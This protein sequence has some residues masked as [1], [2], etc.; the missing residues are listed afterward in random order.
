MN[1]HWFLPRI[2]GQTR[3]DFRFAGL[4]AIL[5]NKQRWQAWRMMDL[6]FIFFI[7]HIDW[8]LEMEVEVL[9]IRV[10]LVPSKSHGREYLVEITNQTPW[11]IVVEDR[12]SPNLRHFQVPS[13]SLKTVPFIRKHDQRGNRIRCLHLP[14]DT[15]VLCEGKPGRNWCIYVAKHGDKVVCHH[16]C[17]DGS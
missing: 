13:R 15:N 8:R 11:V 14:V 6:P 3:A 9:I 5:R 12:N 7:V 4:G 17:V 10:I 16:V 2:F 1:Q